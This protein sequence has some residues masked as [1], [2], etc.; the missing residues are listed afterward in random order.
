MLMKG[1][2]QKHNMIVYEHIVNE[3]LVS[4]SLKWKNQYYRELHIVQLGRGGKLEKSYI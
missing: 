3:G 4:A 2:P 1:Q